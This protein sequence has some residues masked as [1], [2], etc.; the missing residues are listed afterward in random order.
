MILY[1][2]AQ[3]SR[4]PLNSPNNYEL[5]AGRAARNTDL[6]V[7]DRQSWFGQPRTKQIGLWLPTMPMH[8]DQCCKLSGILMPSASRFTIALK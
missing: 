5:M 3:L 6:P 7:I 2:M 1:Q 4:W 8:C